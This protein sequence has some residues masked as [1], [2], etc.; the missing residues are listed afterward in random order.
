MLLAVVVLETAGAGAFKP[1]TAL[2]P[3]VNRAMGFPQW[4]IFFIH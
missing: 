4:L 3:K 1:P 2:S